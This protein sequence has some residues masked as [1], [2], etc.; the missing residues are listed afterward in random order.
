MFKNAGNCTCA[1]VCDDRAKE[2]TTEAQRQ[3]RGWFY[4]QKFKLTN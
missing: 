2:L 1:I 4:S 3:Q